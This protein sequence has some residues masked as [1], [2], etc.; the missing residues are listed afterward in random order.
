M[1]FQSSRT[2]TRPAASAARTARSS[3][4]RETPPRCAHART[5]VVD[6]CPRVRVCGECKPARVQALAVAG[7]SVVGR[8]LYGV[9]PLR[10]K[11]LNVRGMD[12]KVAVRNEEVSSIV[13]IL[14]LDFDKTYDSL[15]AARKD[16]R[17]GHV[18][19]MADQDHD[20]SH[21]K[22]LVINL[23]HTFW[24]SLLQCEDFVEHFVTPIMKVGSRTVGAK[25]ARSRLTVTQWCVRGHRRGAALKRACSCPS[26]SSRHGSKRQRRARVI[27]S[28]STTRVLAP[29]LPLRARSTSPTCSRSDARSRGRAVPMATRS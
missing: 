8:D 7:L 25:W 6:G 26:P 2:Q 13:A 23:F 15:A 11:L 9:F 20:G 14:G 10:G 12:P 1:P 16:L 4:P 27:G 5:C 24:P 19:I 18:M 17:Y 3:S 21:I 28:S 29:T 22:G